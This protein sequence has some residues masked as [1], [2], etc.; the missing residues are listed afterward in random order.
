MVNRMAAYDY[1]LEW[2]YEKEVISIV[3]YVGNKK[4]KMKNSLS[5]NGNHYA[6]KLLDIRDMDSGLF[7]ESD[8]PREIILAMLAGRDEEQ[9]LTVKKIISKLQRLTV[10]ESELLER[11]EELEMISL[12]RGRS[13]QHF[14]IQQKELMPIIVDIRK[15]YRF[16]KGRKAGKLEGRS[17]TLKEFVSYLLKHTNHTIPEIAAMAGTNQDFVLNVKREL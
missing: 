8:N 14:I 12:L 5:R 4:M 2:M 7:L 13:I 15:D 1:T 16:Q 10:S 17:E 3:I 6:F 11:L 9:E